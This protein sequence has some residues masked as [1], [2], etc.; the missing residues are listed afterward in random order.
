MS[1]DTGAG[2]ENREVPAAGPPLSADD[3]VTLNEQIAAMARAGLPLD[4]GLLALAREGGTA[5]RGYFIG[6]MVCLT[7]MG[8]CVFVAEFWFLWVAYLALPL[9]G[10]AM[11]LWVMRVSASTSGQLNQATEQLAIDMRAGFTLPQAIARQGA[12]MPP[13]YGALLTAGIRCGRIGEVLATLTLYA[14]SV[15]DF[16]STL[17]SALLYPA[18]V[19][20]L[21]V[22]LLLFIGN[23]V[24]PTYVEIFKDF[25]MKLP[26][27]SEVVLW[28][29]QRPLELLVIP[30]AAVASLLLAIWL[31]LRRTPRGRR[32]WTGAVYRLPVIGTLLRSARLA[33]FADLLGIL[34]GQN[35]PLPEALRL[36]AEASSDPL[37]TQGAQR[38][39]EDIS[40]G[41][42][43]GAALH[44]QSL[45]PELVVW[46]IGFGER[47]GT[48]AP[49]LR[50]VAQ[51]YRRQA[52][53]RAVLLRAM[54]PP[55]L[56]IILAGS[57]GAL[58][59][60]GLMAPFFELLDGLSGGGK[61]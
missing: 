22:A 21:G 54:L 18:L 28:I 24:L 45:V 10:L 41:V 50:Q 11:I 35:I 6:I 60:F 61:K 40:Q 4:Q 53:T 55:I 20:V 48:L 58:F 49:A 15:S 30:T 1:T 37:L 47:Q 23:F 31:S 32:I 26:F 14:R 27:L 3:L 34:V 5:H 12:R 51:L 59:I 25:K 29:G 9:V 42:P 46:M 38:V 33:A 16:R 56:V 57:L 43:L 44:A 52:E 7:L 19:L 17:I 8:V 13:Y 2:G 36:A 39:E